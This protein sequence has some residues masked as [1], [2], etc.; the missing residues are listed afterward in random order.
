MLIFHHPNPPECGI[1][2][3]IKGPLSHIS[4]SSSSSDV[5]IVLEIL[6]FFR[7]LRLLFLLHVSCPSL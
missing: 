1:N 6:L 2:P 7:P 4:S 5:N 3:Y